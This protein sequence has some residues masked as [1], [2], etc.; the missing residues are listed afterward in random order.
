ML[1]VVYGDGGRHARSAAQRRRVDVGLV[2]ADDGIGRAQRNDA[3]STRW[4][5][6]VDRVA[7]VDRQRR[8]RER[9][10]GED[11]DGVG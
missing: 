8:R 11:R 4:A 7:F 2:H 1:S 10:I 3:G 9:A 6:E 5:D